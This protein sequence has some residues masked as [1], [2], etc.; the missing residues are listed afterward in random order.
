MLISRRIHRVT[1]IVR[2]VARG[3]VGSDGVTFVLR[4]GDFCVYLE[5]DALSPLWKGRRFP[6]RECISGWVMIHARPVVIPDI[7]KDERIPIEAYSPTFVRSIA[8]APIGRDR[9]IGAIGAYWA[10]AGYEPTQSQIDA[11]FMLADSAALA[12]EMD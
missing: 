4:D 9:P 6:M 12:L 10:K 11:L 3:L 8:M 1:E 7:F 2:S 5:E